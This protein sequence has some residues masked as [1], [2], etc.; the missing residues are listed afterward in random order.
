[1]NLTFQAEFSKNDHAVSKCDMPVERTVII[2]Y[3]ISAL[4]VL[5]I[6][7]HAILLECWGRKL[8]RN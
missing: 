2:I 5:A 8:K 3:I 1:M 6:I 7:L 4:V